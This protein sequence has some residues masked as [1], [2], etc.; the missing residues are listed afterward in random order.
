[1]L[2]AGGQKRVPEEFLKDWRASLPPL[3]TQQRIAGYLDEKTAQI[4]GLIE[5]KRA[6]LEGL[7]EKRQALITRAATK[8][9]NVDTV[10]KP[11]GIDWLGDIP[12]HWVVSSLGYRYEVQLGRMLNAERSDGDHLKPY[13]RVYDVQWGK[14]T[15]DDL[16]LMDFPPGAQIRYRL[17]LGDLLVNE[18]GSYVGRSA[19]WRGE[20]EECYYQKALHRLRPFHSESDT[21]EF[22]YFVMEMATKNGVFVAGG[23]Q[24]TIDHLTAEQLRHYKFAFP[25]IE[26]QIQITE[27]LKRRLSEHERIER[28]VQVSM[29]LLKELR[30]AIVNS[31]ITGQI[32]VPQ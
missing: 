32:A 28:F 8:G 21:A 26:E 20:L 22:L 24:T 27:M 3:E 25:P 29:D 4:D 7:A 12:A 19:I 9:L 16:P 6:L 15:V 30:A 1:M 17:R 14:I 18:G 23:N 11:S 31:A 5:K 10:M 13:L 2:G